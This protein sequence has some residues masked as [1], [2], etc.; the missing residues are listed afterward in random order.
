MGDVFSILRAVSKSKSF[1]LSALFLV[2]YCAAMGEKLR[3]GSGAKLTMAKEA[4]RV[5]VG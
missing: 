5:R 4:Y 3:A 2:S 1:A